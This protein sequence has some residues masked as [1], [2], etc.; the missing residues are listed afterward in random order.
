MR[1][2]AALIVLAGCDTFSSQAPID[3]RLPDDGFVP[4]ARTVLASRHTYVIDSFRL[5]ATASEA[6]QLGLDVDG[7]LADGIDNQLGTLLASL[8]SLAPELALGDSLARA[9]ATG[10][11]I[12]LVD[13]RV[14]DLFGA[15]AAQV[16]LRTGGSPQPPPCE[17]AGDTLCRKHLRGDATFAVV[18]ASDELLDGQLLSERVAA[19][20][21][22][23]VVPFRFG[24]QAT[25]A[26]P[27]R[28]ARVEL[29]LTPEAIRAGSKLGGAIARADVTALVVPGIHAE[30]TAVVERDCPPPRQAPTCGCAPSSTGASVLG[31]FDGNDD[32]ILALAETRATL[33][34]VLTSDIDLD[35]DGVNDAV[36]L[37]VG[38]TGVHGDF[39]EAP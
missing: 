19:G 31:I 2:A 8:A 22:T 12:A 13:V 35:G 6:T 28:R 30:V 32:C 7:R 16:H 39:P 11:V 15:G 21:G 34:G 37:G 18:S 5:P 33:D 3:S 36:S 38:V 14:D 4:D 26:L 27:L 9:V 17:G 1:L 10:G 29:A 23:V 20:P 25:V 24:G